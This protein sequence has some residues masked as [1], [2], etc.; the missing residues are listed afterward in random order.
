M[1]RQ[2]DAPRCSKCVHIFTYFILRQSHQGDAIITP[3]LLKNTQR[4]TCPNSPSWDDKAGMTKLGFDPGHSLVQGLFLKPISG[5]PPCPPRVT[6]VLLLGSDFPVPLGASSWPLPI[7][8]PPWGA[9]RG[10]WCLWS[11]STQSR[12]PVLL[13][14]H[15]VWHLGEWPCQVLGPLCPRSLSVFASWQM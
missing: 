13:G 12:T 8:L 6:A 9:L 7:L 4:H 2:L 11:C 5:L 10:S 1:G 14:T 3:V 15:V